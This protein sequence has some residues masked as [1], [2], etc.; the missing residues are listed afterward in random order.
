MHA[1]HNYY[2]R[3]QLVGQQT[4]SED[5]GDAAA[6]PGLEEVVFETNQV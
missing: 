5:E 4:S 6:Q 2:Q 3:L 1:N